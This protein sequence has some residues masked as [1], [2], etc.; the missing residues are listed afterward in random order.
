MLRARSC[1]EAFPIKETRGKAVAGAAMELAA[2]L[3]IG[4]RP[5]RLAVGVGQGCD[6]R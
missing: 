3:G 5:K 1:Y 6:A 4:E 2:K